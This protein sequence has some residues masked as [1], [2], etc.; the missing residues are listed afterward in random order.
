MHS[1]SPLRRPLPRRPAAWLCRAKQ[2]LAIFRPGLRGRAPAN[3]SAATSAPL[4]ALALVVGACT[5]APART[6]PDPLPE[7]REWALAPRPAGT[8]LGLVLVENDSGSL[9]ELSFAPGARV[10]RVVANSPAA[11][12]GIRVDDVVLEMDGHEIVAPADVEAL[13]GASAGGRTAKLLVQ[14]GD[15][16][17]DVSVQLV[18][19]GDDVAQVRPAFHLDPA[20]TR[21]AWAD[22]DVGARLVA[23]PDEG[24]SRRIPV[25]TLITHVDDTPVASGR[26]LIQVV[27]T[28]PPGSDVTLRGRTPDGDETEFDVELLGE[29][30]VLTGVS[31]PVLF[32][33]HAD[34][35]ADRRNFVL[36][37]LWI[38]SL[39]R[40]E[41]DG[42]E[43]HWRMLRFFEWSSGVGELSR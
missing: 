17:F 37:D 1:K 41:R 24:P 29:G 33:Y 10:T 6:I 32:T 11:T 21:A 20:R 26:A 40:Y 19:A 31:V 42:G 23:R 9:E 35:E 25:G 30:R 13:L 14:R 36:L 16:V 8:F 2:S 28:R 15:T 27:G 12:A 3:L 43:R 39:F 38:I 4:A 5:S 7:V 34:L 22:G 18:A